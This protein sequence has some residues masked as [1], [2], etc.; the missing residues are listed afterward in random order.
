MS[1]PAVAA[2]WVTVDVDVMTMPDR[3]PL[4]L[5]SDNEDRRIQTMTENPTDVQALANV[6]MDATKIHGG[7]HDELKAH[8]YEVA[9]SVLAALRANT[10]QGSAFRTAVGVELSQTTLMGKNLRAAMDAF[11]K[12]GKP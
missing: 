5:I 12:A 4:P 10:E 9:D 11:T 7:L 2:G 1:P 3:D 6:M 8:Q